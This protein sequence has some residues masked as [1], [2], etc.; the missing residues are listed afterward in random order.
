MKWLKSLGWLDIWGRIACIFC[1]TIGKS[2]VM[3]AE[4][5]SEESC[6]GWDGESGSFLF[7]IGWKWVAKKSL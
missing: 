6:K 1:R 7:R 5:A 2:A 3:N 4:T